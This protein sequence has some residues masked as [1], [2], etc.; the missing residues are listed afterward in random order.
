MWVWVCVCTCRRGGG[1][2][3]LSLEV[4]GVGDSFP[5]RVV[6]GLAGVGEGTK[7]A[8]VME[9]LGLFKALSCSS[10]SFWFA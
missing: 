6:I 5:A 3:D 4:V 10:A 9:L 2:L 1:L 8:V 7:L